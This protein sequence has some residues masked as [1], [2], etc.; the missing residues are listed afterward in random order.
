LTQPWAW[1]LALEHAY[2][3]AQGQKLQS[4][5]M[6]R[7]EEAG[8]PPEETQGKPK[9]PGSLPLLAIMAENSNG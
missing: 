1:L 2:L 6:S 8:E 3:L 9:H 5:L 4:E 7:A